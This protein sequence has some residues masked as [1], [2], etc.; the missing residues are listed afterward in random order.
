MTL[1]VSPDDADADAASLTERIVESTTDVAGADPLDLPPLYDAVDPDALE[2]LYDRD[3]ADGPE[4]EFT[5]AGC[6]VTVRGDGSVSV[7]PEPIGAGESAV[8]EGASLSPD[9]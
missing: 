5:Y 6:G 3:G 8:V 9:C 4:V 1:N 7:T 2:A